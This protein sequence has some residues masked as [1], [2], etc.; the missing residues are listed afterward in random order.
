MVLARRGGLDGDVGGGAS[1]CEVHLGFAFSGE[2]EVHG[3]QGA[4]LASSA[5]F[6]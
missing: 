5:G 3:V 6:T 4:D 2:G 1:G